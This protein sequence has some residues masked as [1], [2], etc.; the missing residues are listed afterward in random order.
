MTL[1]H[2]PKLRQHDLLR[3]VKQRLRATGISEDLYNYP[4]CYPK[5][6]KLQCEAWLDFPCPNEWFSDSALRSSNS[7]WKTVDFSHDVIEVSQPIKSMKSAVFHLFNFLIL[8]ED[9]QYSNLTPSWSDSPRPKQ[10]QHCHFHQL[11]SKAED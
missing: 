7:E 4:N 8:K 6:E 11:F 9:S 2:R 1:M 5:F 10:R 3:S